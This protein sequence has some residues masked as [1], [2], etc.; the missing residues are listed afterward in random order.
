[1]EIDMGIAERIHAIQRITPVN[2]NG[3]C[4]SPSASSRANLTLLNRC[5][6]QSRSDNNHQYFSD[7]YQHCNIVGFRKYCLNSNC[8]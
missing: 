6:Y 1:M 5:W 4:V 8:C 2:L 3:H 7:L